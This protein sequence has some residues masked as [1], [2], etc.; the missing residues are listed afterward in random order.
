MPTT[1]LLKRLVHLSKKRT[2]SID[3]YVYFDLKVH[4]VG[5]EHSVFPN[6]VCEI[7]NFYKFEQQNS[8][9]FFCCDFFPGRD[10]S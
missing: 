2:L 4:I 9:K 6:Y 7:P 8:F 10:I 1:R 3:S 5:I